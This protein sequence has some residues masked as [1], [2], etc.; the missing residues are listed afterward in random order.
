MSRLLSALRAEY[1][2]PFAVAGAA[3]VVA[4]SELMTVF[5]LDAGTTGETIKTIEASDRHYY[6]LLVLAV[7][8]LAALATALVTGSRPAAA[9]VAVAGGLALLIFLLVDLPDVNQEG[10]LED[11]TFEFFATKAEPANGFWLEMAGTI[12]L[13][14]SGGALATLR[15]DQLTLLYSRLREATRPERTLAAGPE[16]DEG[17]AGGESGE[18]EAD[19]QEPGPREPSLS[20][21]QGGG[22]S[23]RARDYQR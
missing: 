2:L 12:A 21:T 5:E 10:S 23:E 17:S 22:R 9:A 4:A 16:P 13:A 20:R 3:V 14:V 15:P 1:L 7:F 6:S 11:S 19:S 8:A 18:E